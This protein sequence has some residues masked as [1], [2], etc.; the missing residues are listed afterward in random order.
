M[1]KWRMLL[2]F[3]WQ[4]NRSL[5]LLSH[6]QLPKWQCH[7]VVLLI[8][9]SQLVQN[10]APLQTCFSPVTYFSDCVTVHPNAPIS[11]PLLIATVQAHIIPYLDCFNSSLTGFSTLLHPSITPLPRIIF[12]KFQFDHGTACLKVFQGIPIAFKVNIQTPQ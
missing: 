1:K 6:L 7:L 8:L 11:F 10:S 5:H 2:T 3:L 12:L 9:Q 4:I